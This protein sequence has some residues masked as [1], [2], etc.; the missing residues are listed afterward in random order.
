MG[1]FGGAAK[2]LAGGPAVLF[3]ADPADAVAEAL[4]GYDPAARVRGDR[5]V[6]GTGVLL[7]GPVEITPELARKAALPDGMTVGYYAEIAP[8]AKARGRSDDEKRQEAERLV[9]GLA[10]RLGGTVHDARPP[11]ELKLG[12]SVYS[13]Q[14]LSAEEVIGVL[15]PFL[16][17]KTIV[18]RPTAQV[19]GGYSLVTIQGANFFT[20]YWPPWLSRRNLVPPPPAIG[21]LSQQNPGRWELCTDLPVLSD[22]AAASTSAA[23]ADAATADAATADAATAGRDVALTVGRAALALAARSGGEVVDVYG[24]PV[25]RPEDLLPR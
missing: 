21:E 14:S 16:E 18:V 11:M 13:G 3:A 5:F 23:T 19:E 4:T 7:T 9:R 25:G 15:Q 6:L 24:F 22:L 2:R 8:A 17:G 12:A 1:L 10:A 20:M